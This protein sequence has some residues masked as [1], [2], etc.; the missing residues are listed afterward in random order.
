MASLDETEKWAAVVGCLQYFCRP[1][2]LW[3]S[4]EKYFP[5]AT[6]GLEPISYREALLSSLL[7]AI[8]YIFT[9]S[10]ECTGIDCK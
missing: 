2:N 4:N 9:Q 6:R 8:V 3:E 1:E 10:A 7:Y 5:K